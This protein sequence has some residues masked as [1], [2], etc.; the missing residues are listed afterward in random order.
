MSSRT[1]IRGLAYT[2]VL[3]KTLTNGTYRVG[4]LSDP[5]GGLPRS[6]SS[7]RHA[8]RTVSGRCFNVGPS[9]GHVLVADPLA[10]MFES[11]VVRRPER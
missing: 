11:D 7:R 10:L 8:E 9:E 6:G 5:H 2:W 4:R 3:L 1:D